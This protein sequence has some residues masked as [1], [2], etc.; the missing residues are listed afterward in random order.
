MLEL[1]KNEIDLGELEPGTKKNFQI[2]V[3][4]TATV[5][6]TPTITASCG[7]TIPN[8]EP[9]TI[10]ADGTAQ[11]LAEFDTINK[12]GPQTKNIYVGYSENGKTVKLVLTFK[13]NVKG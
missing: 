10:P 6:V 13:A 7:C 5:P 11:L 3:K 9:K 12:K 2:T 1:S 8:L 4:N